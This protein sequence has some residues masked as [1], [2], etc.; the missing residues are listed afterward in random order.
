MARIKAVRYKGKEFFLNHLSANDYYSEKEKITGVWHGKLADDFQLQNMPVTADVFS[1]FQQNLNPVTLSKLTQRT[2][3][4]G[5]RF[6]DFQWF[7]MTF[8]L[9]MRTRVRMKAG[10]R[11][12]YHVVMRH[13]ETM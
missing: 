10:A 9:A 13:A 2:V 6:Y 11:M 4:G 8:E 5:I 1:L 7:S 12:R 3:N